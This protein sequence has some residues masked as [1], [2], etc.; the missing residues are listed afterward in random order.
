MQNCAL[1]STLSCMCA[2]VRSS[3]GHESFNP[4]LPKV[5]VIRDCICHMEHATS[6][7][8]LSLSL[9][10]LN[11]AGFANRTLLSRNKYTCLERLRAIQKTTD[12]YG[13]LSRLSQEHCQSSLLH[14]S[15]I[16]REIAYYQ[17]TI[18]RSR[19]ANKPSSKTTLLDP[20][21]VSLVILNYYSARTQCG[22][23]GIA[24]KTAWFCA[25]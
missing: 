21:I 3:V 24:V 25:P 14:I 8:L 11:Q 12:R 4:P 19:D 17:Y 22:I 2:A 16:F 23:P 20:P 10:S 13:V 7:W 5:W 1:S 9:W 18:V 6:V 15:A